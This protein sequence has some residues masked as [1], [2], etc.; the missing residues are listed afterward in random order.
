MDVNA[1]L[2]L[3]FSHGLSRLAVPFFLISAG[4]FLDLNQI[5]QSIHR[6]LK[7]Y[8]KWTLYYLP[9]IFL[10]LGY[11]QADPLTKILTLIRD[12]F[13]QGTV[14]HLW[15]L[16]ASIFAFWMMDVLK[17][18]MSLKS[19]VIL[20]FLLMSIGVFA[21]AYS[22][23][24]TPDSF[25]YPLQQTYLEVF[26]SS[27]NGLFFAFLYISLGAYLKENPSAFNVKQSLLG[28]V[29]FFSL[30]SVEL[31]YIIEPKHPIDY[32]YYFS[33]L[34]AIY[35]LFNLAIKLKLK[36]SKF[37]RHLRHL[38]SSM[39]FSHNLIYYS[40]L[41]ILGFPSINSVERFLI[42]A[43]LTTVISFYFEFKKGKKNHEKNLSV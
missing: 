19:M 22:G 15:Y 14:L 39:Y 40:F 6:Y 13:F 5:K 4:Y 31:F 24:I 36:S 1:S 20:G 28:F 3:F 43:G 23:F 7:L 8:L 27:R 25:L 33:L 37:D 18:K 10:A 29:F 2:D 17:D 21:D 42:A 16:P 35:F 11:S 34:F 26:A 38:S 12:A 9:F 30:M 32:N 41:F